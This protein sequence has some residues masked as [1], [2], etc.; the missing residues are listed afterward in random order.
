M[1]WLAHLYLAEPSVEF[2]LGALLPDL[3]PLA[4]WQHL[5]AP[6]LRGA[7][8]HQMI[9][10]YTDA[11]PVVRRSIARIPPPLRRFAPILIDVYYDHL[12]LTDW[13]RHT[14]CA[15]P[16]FEAD[17]YHAID[18]STGII[19]EAA[20]ERLARMRAHHWLREYA[21]PE[22]IERTLERIG[23]RLRKPQHL[24]AATAL[25]TRHHP[26]LADDFAEFFPQ[27]TARVA[28]DYAIG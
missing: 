22:G 14:G 2:R 12:L 3:L 27:L 9:D 1:N 28:T 26:A 6:I 18:H 7:R 11:H 16:A 5:P 10:A 4:Q 8:C 23:G 21:T 17:I 25:L 13:Q 20:R 15:F 24:G 19:P